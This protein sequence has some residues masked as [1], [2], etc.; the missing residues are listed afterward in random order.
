MLAGI[1][2]LAA[3]RAAVSQESLEPGHKCVPGDG[4]LQSSQRNSRLVERR[5]PW[6]VQTLANHGRDR[7]SLTP[8]GL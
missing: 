7:M 8:S 1:F 3:P 6:K 2:N 4:I 5:Y